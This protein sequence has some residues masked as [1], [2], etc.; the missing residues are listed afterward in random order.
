[1]AN[2]YNVVIDGVIDTKPVPDLKCGGTLLLGDGGGYG[3]NLPDSMRDITI[4]N[5]ICKSRH[6]VMIYGFLTDSTISN[7]I[8]KN[9]N[10]ETIRITRENGIKNVSFTN[11]VTAE[12]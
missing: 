5:V 12:N 4:S 8:N 6:A 9:P 2:I 7:V 10:G 11:I 3:E 1:M